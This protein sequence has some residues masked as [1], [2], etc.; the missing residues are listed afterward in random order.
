METCMIELSI[1]KKN[2]AALI[3]G[4]H[5]IAFSEMSAYLIFGI[6]PNIFSTL[7]DNIYNQADY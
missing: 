2:Y 3:Y 1:Y 4:I 7:L 5:L 6:F